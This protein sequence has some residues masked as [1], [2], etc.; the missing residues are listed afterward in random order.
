MW[1]LVFAGASAVVIA[2]ST[3]VYAQNRD[4]APRSQPR[5]EDMRAF[6]DARLAALKAGLVLTP[7]Q[8]KNWPA[9]EQAARDFQ[10]LRLDRL[11]EGVEARR[12]GRSR[13]ND[14]VAR[15]E[16]RATALSE[17]GTALKKLADATG[18]LYN[19]LDDSQK[20]RFAILSRL[21]REDRARGGMRDRM[22]RWMEDGRPGFFRR[23]ENEPRNYMRERDRSEAPIRGEERL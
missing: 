14:P 12:S 8:E 10:K 7:E 3:F 6:A 19:S 15:M 2:G 13:S 1:K 11:R 4:Q 23:G 17:T 9:F 18:P 21:G 5:M 16:E 20:R 22:R